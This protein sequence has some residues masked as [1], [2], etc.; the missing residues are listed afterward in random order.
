MVRGC[1]KDLIIQ[2][3]G[4]AV[5]KVCAEVR[6]FNAVLRAVVLVVR[7]LWSVLRLLVVWRLVSSPM[8][9]PM[10]TVSSKVEGAVSSW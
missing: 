1:W 10:P 8:I 6:R 7:C 2:A 5:Y 9:N 4:K 3:M